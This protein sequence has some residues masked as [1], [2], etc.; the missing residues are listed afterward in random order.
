M[1]VEDKKVNFQVDCGASVN[2]LPPKFTTGQDVKPTDKKLR[3]WNEA[4]VKPIGTSA[5]II[6]NPKTKKRFGVK[7]V[8]VVKISYHLLGQRLLNK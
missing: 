3:M 8:I 5:V 2:I 4:E 6:Q 7:F 1:T